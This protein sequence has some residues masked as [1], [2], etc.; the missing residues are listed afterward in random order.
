[1]VEENKSKFWVFDVGERVNDI[2]NKR[3]YEK[4]G[5]GTPFGAASCAEVE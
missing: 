1:M 4:W 5:E 3:R 2:N